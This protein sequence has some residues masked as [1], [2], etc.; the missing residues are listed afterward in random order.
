M[1]LYHR[2]LAVLNLMEVLDQKNRVPSFTK[3]KAFSGPTGIKMQY[4]LIF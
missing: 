3:N 2:E 4:P 1:K